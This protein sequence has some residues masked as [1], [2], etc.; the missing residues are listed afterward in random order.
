MLLRKRLIATPIA[1][2][3]SVHKIIRTLKIQNYSEVVNYEKVKVNE[4]YETSDYDMFKLSK[5]NRNVA[6]RKELFEEAKKVL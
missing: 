5:S 3:P 1:N 6:Y 2:S 4:I